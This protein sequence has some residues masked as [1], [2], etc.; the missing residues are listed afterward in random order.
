MKRI[1]LSVVLIAGFLSAC[2]KDENFLPYPEQLTLD[3]KAIDDYLDAHAINAIKDS[4]GLRY[5]I[6]T[7]GNGIKPA[8]AESRVYIRQVIN[9]LAGGNVGVDTT[10]NFYTLGSLLQGQQIGLK[11][12]TKGSYYTLYVPSGLAYGNGSVGSVGPNTILVFEMKLIDDDAQLASELTYL[13]SYLDSVPNIIEDASGL[14]LRILNEGGQ[15]HP[16]INNSIIFN[17]AGKILKTKAVIGSGTN[18]SA[19]MVNLIEA[20]Q[21]GMP[22]IGVGGRVRM[23]VP[24]KLAYGFTGSNPAYTPVIPPKSILYYDVTLNGF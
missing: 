7:I 17:Y 24:S 9:T 3:V 18:V 15:S 11:L 13:D 6:H 2:N 20:F 14:R 5:V 23:Y 16:T 1:V 10:G 4:S 19:P 22:Y 8:S 21:I 12:M